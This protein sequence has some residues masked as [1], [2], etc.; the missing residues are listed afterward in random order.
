[1]YNSLTWKVGPFSFPWVPAPSMC[2]GP[3]RLSKALLHPFSGSTLYHKASFA[4]DPSHPLNSFTKKL[5]ITCLQ[6]SCACR[7]PIHSAV[8]TKRC[9]LQDV[10]CQ[11]FSHPILCID[12]RS[13]R[14][15]WSSLLKTLCIKWHCQSFRNIWSTFRL[16]HP[17]HWH[18]IFCI[19]AAKSVP[20]TECPS[21]S[22]L[23]SI[24]KRRFCPK[25]FCLIMGN[26]CCIGS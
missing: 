7:A 2:R 6:R 4:S 11:K 3:A 24:I 13:W 5:P 17:S 16:N 1:M 14:K 25:S 26:A 19:V 20:V 18:H 9:T 10:R 8:K 12:L 15:A 21:R 22:R 23:S